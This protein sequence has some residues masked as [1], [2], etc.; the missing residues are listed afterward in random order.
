[1]NIKKIK[2]TLITLGV[3]EKDIKSIMTE[4][5]YIKKFY[6]YM[7]E[8]YN[9]SSDEEVEDMIT[10]YITTNI[11]DEL[12]TSEKNILDLTPKLTKE[13][14]ILHKYYDPN[15][16]EVSTRRYINILNNTILNNNNEK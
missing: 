2:G 16:L 13:F 11:D 1:M 3:N 4:L 5:E 6:N 9:L 8:K 15:E 14:A 12:L 10:V 7:I